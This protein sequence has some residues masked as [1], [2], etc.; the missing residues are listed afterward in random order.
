[1]LLV[2]GKANVFA[3]RLGVFHFIGVWPIQ[4]TPRKSQHPEG[5]G[6]HV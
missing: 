4:L 5:I 3:K 6:S 1:M 2:D